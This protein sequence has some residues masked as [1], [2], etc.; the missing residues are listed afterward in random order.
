MTRRGE[1]SRGRGQT[2]QNDALARRGG[3]GRQ[4][5]RSNTGLCPGP[6]AEWA[7]APTPQPHTGELGPSGVGGG[8]KRSPPTPSTAPGHTC[9]DFPADV[10]P[11]PTL[12]PPPLTCLLTLWLQ[13]DPCLDPL[14]RTHIREGSLSPR[15]SSPAAH[16]SLKVK[17]SFLAQRSGPLHPRLP[18]AFTSLSM[19][20]P[21][22]LA[23]AEPQVV[24]KLP[25][26]FPPP[27]MPFQPSSSC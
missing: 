17:F 16:S 19:H 12:S 23:H 27:T 2:F 15:K 26:L 8:V 14:S 9:R 22:G 5:R 6:A 1:G 24:P 25:M 18:W 21:L 7:P 11:H 4:L 13:L 3:G 10:L 20:P